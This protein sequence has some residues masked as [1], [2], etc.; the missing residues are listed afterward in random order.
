[1]GSHALAAAFIPAPYAKE[2]LFFF[3]DPNEGEWRNDVGAV[4]KNM[5]EYYRNEYYRNK[6][7]QWEGLSPGTAN[8]NWFEVQVQSVS[9][10]QL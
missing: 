6:K 8:Y 10:Y 4:K 2:V 9:K 1:M 3:F 7:I 5:Q